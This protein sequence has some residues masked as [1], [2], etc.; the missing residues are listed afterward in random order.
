MKGKKKLFKKLFNE[1]VG[2]GKSFAEL[3]LT[4]GKELESRGYERC[5]ECND[6]TKKMA[7]HMRRVHGRRNVQ[8]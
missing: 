3:S 7:R 1:W 8:R 5:A 2:T 4:W 6:W